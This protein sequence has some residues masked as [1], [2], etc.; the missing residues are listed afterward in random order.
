MVRW[1]RQGVKLGWL[2]WFGLLLGS[3]WAQPDERRVPAFNTYE[4]R[5]FLV[6]KS[7]AGLAPEL[8]KLLNRHLPDRVQLE[9]HNVPRQRL[10]SFHLSPPEQFAGLA[11]F[12]APAF[13][14]DAQ[15]QLYLWSDVLFEDRN[16]VV[17]PRQQ[18][19][20]RLELGWF[21]GKLMV[22]VRGQRYS[23]FDPLLAD[24]RL[25]RKEV[26]D[27]RSALKMVLLERAD[28]TQMNQLMFRDLVRELGLQE[29][30]VGLPEPGGGAFKRRILVGRAA[31]DLLPW[32][33]QA[34]A[35]LHCDS[36]WRRLA[37][38]HG[39]AAQ[40]CATEARGSGLSA[41]RVPASTSGLKGPGRAAVPRSG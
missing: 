27:E 20:G 7:R 32:L 41:P 18:A 12:L 23:V 22:G 25:Q 30:L 6:P 2:A 39:F 11:L 31:A 8:V 14:G 28:F 35:R 34:I 16:V 29:Q 19:P 4:A 21:R 33:N 17:L 9:L 15:Q 36:E 5:P 37:E 40:A 24:G 10:L 3:A 26:S 13:V 1:S 38:Q